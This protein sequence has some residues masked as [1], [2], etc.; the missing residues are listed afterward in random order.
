MDELANRVVE[1]LS[2]SY[3]W[4]ELVFAPAAAAGP[5]LLHG[6]LWLG[7]ILPDSR[8]RPFALDPASW[9]ALNFKS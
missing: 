4:R 2:D 8:G 5:R 7:S 9:S 1:R 6:D 3:V